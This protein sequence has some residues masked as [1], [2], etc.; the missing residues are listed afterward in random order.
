M[1]RLEPRRVV[2]LAA[3]RLRA[4]IIGGSHPI[5]G[6]LPAERAL[7]ESLGIS[8]LTLRAAV[9]RLE[10]EGLVRARQ[11]SGVHICDW[12][13]EGE[14][15]LLP[16]LI[17]GGG[18]ALIAPFLAL[19]RAVACEAVALATERA[20]D[21]EIDDLDAAAQ[22]L[23]EEDDLAVLEAGNLAFAHWVVALAG[24]LPMTLL[25]NTVARVYAAQ[26][27]LAGLLD[28]DRPGVRASFGAIVTLLRQRD[29]DAAR[30][31]VRLMLEA[32]DAQVVARSE[33]TP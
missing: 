9:S 13:A 27:D 10:G 25:F 33:G 7:S 31:A 20:T 28:G 16:H 6:T 12:R 5:G 29:P 21:A 11:G 30:Q 22:A 24:N 8:R 3:D 2:D 14:V 23:A 17:A 1:S 18:P 19:R 15:T 32:L 4:E 26:P